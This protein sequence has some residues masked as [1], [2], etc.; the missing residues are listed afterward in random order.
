MAPTLQN[1]WLVD[2]VEF[3][4]ETQKLNLRGVADRIEI[5]SGAELTYA[6]SVFFC[7]GGVHGE[8]RMTLHYVDLSSGVVLLVRPLRVE[9][10]P[11]ETTDVTVRFNRIPVPHEGAYAWELWYGLEPLS[12][13]RVEVQVD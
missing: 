9:G 12:T 8:A 11:L 10:T 1:L 6:A 5:P 3:D 2:A 7:V 4:E 13:L